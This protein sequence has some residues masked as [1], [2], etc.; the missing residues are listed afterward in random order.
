M[1]MQKL[2]GDRTLPTIGLG[3]VKS[4]I[5]H[6]EAAAGLAG[7]VKVLGA[8]ERGMIPPTLHCEEINPHID[9]TATPFSIVRTPTAW[10][11]RTDAAGVELPRRAGVSSFGF[12]GV[13]AHVVIEE[14][15]DGCDRRPPLPARAFAETRFWIPGQAVNVLSSGDETLLHV[16]RWNG[17]SC[18]VRDQ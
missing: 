6:L 3:A 7:V 5:G 1:P 14:Y 13:N 4:N 2:A 16:P 17:W 15:A 8:M 18:P 11:R 9:L 10:L 12:G